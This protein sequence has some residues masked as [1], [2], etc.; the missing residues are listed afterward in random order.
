ME[1]QN[2]PDL[3]QMG[4]KLSVRVGKISMT[5]GRTNTPARKG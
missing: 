3:E 5:T 4:R 2:V 1:G